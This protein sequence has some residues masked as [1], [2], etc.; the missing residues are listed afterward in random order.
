MKSTATW[1]NLFL[2]GLSQKGDEVPTYQESLDL[3]KPLV[4]VW[5]TLPITGNTASLVLN[6]AFLNKTKTAQHDYDL[7]WKAF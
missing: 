2:D 4:E 6:F 1:N 3:G 7:L 5:A